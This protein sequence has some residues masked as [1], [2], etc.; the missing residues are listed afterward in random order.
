M[1]RYY[2]FDQRS[3]KWFVYRKGKWTGSIAIDL[4]AGKKVPPEKNIPDNKY[5]QRG[6]ILEPLAAEAYEHKTGNKMAHFGF[7]TNSKYPHAG[8]SPDGI[9]PDTVDEIKCM[10]VEKHMAIGEGRLPMPTDYV[11]QT[12]FGLVITEL[13]KIRFILYNP[14]APTPLFIIDFPVQQVIIDN[15]ISKLEAL[16]PKG[17]PSSIRAKQKYVQENKLKIR[18]TRHKAYLKAKAKQHGA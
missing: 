7:V 18:E 3:P 13:H 15:I 1:I 8:Y 4:L 5:M 16:K 9:E 2:N 12:H 10:N 11:A 17:R 6:R 14:D